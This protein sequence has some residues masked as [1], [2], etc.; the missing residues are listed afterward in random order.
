MT[1]TMN[2]IVPNV[3]ELP[4]SLKLNNNSKYPPPIR[5]NGYIIDPNKFRDGIKNHEISLREIKTLLLMMLRGNSNFVS[6]L[7]KAKSNGFV[8]IYT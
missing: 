5:N 7:I 4:V 1:V 3:R 8:D 6:Q 2:S